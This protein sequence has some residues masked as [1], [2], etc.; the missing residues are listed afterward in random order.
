MLGW[1]VQSMHDRAILDA[2]HLDSDAITTL[3]ELVMAARVYQRGYYAVKQEGA[4]EAKVDLM[5]DMLLPVAGADFEE[6]LRMLL[7]DEQ[8]L[9]RLDVNTMV[10]LR[11]RHGADPAALRRAV[12][13]L[14]GNP[15]DLA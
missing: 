3:E 9:S 6:E 7:D 10:D 14:L 12:R 5:V 4:R 1:A 11:F 15:G 8:L 13:K 2:L